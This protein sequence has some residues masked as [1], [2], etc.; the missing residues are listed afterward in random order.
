MWGEWAY[1][2]S[3]AQANAGGG[4][5]LLDFKPPRGDTMLVLHARG[6]I[7]GT[8][9]IF[10]E[11]NDE[12]DSVAVRYATAASGAG[13][14]VTI[15]QSLASAGASGVTIDSTDPLTRLFQGDDYLVIRKGAGAQNDTLV[16]QLRALLAPGTAKPTVDKS[17]ST[18][19]A[20]VTITETENK[21]L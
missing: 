8:A 7:T 17:R 6:L 18:N 4:A 16:V 10:I 15:P 3:V 9:D 14:G 2:A 21:I 13:V 5:I 11:K 19:E 12:D 1:A 20:D